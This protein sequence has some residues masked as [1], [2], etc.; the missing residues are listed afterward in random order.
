[1]CRSSKILQTS[2]VAI[3]QSEDSGDG[4]TEETLKLAT[5]I[6]SKYLDNDKVNVSVKI[7]GTL[8]LGLIDIEQR[9][10]VL[11]LSFAAAL[12]KLLANPLRVFK[13]IL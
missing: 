3:A 11:I 1:M 6:P 5:I 7:N 10:T 2:T 12:S 9:T 8:A 4:D 13:S